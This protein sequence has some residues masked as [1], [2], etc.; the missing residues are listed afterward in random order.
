LLKSYLYFIGCDCDYTKGGDEG[1]K[2]S[3]AAR[4]GRACKCKYVAPLSYTCSGETVDCKAPTN[5]KC[6][7]PDT[8]YSSCVLGLGDCEGYD[9]YF[10]NEYLCRNFITEWIFR[11]R[12]MIIVISFEISILKIHD[13]WL[14]FRRVRIPF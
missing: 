9:D 3:R 4:P 14:Y 7:N 5:E 1:C 6:V 13:I 8:S 11:E 10:N 2:V 12:S